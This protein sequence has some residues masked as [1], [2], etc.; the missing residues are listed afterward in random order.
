MNN[1]QATRHAVALG[2]IWLSAAILS[3]E[4]T[5]TFPPVAEWL[6]PI[7]RGQQR[8]TCV[9]WDHWIGVTASQPNA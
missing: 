2:H 1:T 6:V 4:P 7:A 8:H 5:V 3:A 9:N